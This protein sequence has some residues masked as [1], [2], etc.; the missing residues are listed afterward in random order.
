MGTRCTVTV[1]YRDGGPGT[2]KE[3]GHSIVPEELGIGFK[4]T[5]V[6]TGPLVN[7]LRKGPGRLL[8]HPPNCTV[9]EHIQSS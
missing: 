9:G 3:Y 7:F 5:Q 4:S 6:N 8:L 2:P 1:L